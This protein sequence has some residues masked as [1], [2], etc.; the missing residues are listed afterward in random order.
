MLEAVA[1]YF[2]AAEPLSPV[3]HLLR[4]A[5]R[6]ARGS[7]QQWLDEMVVREDLLEV[8]FKTLDMVKPV[9]KQ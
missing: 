8:I 1:A 4:R 2:A 9:A 5:A 3:P 7:L 6:W